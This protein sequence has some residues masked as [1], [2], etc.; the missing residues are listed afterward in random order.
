MEMV[1][2]RETLEK[3]NLWTGQ[4]SA[5]RENGRDKNIVRVSVLILVSNLF[6]KKMK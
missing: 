2:D 1:D 6:Q 3:T 5:S 4:P